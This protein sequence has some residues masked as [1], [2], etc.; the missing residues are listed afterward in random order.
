MN[1]INKLISGSPG[2]F[3][4]STSKISTCS[5]TTNFLKQVGSI[6]S[7]ES[8]PSSVTTACT[9]APNEMSAIKSE[10]GKARKKRE[11]KSERKQPP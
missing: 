10:C 3:K 2:S 8:K 4:Q 6:N 5:N 9:Y 1:R 7:L 11:V